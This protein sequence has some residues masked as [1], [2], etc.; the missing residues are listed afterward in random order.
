MKAVK[1]HAATKGWRVTSKAT[2]NSRGYL[3]MR[4]QRTRREAPDFEFGDRSM[5]ERIQRYM[6]LNPPPVP[7]IE[8]STKSN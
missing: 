5:E 2:R 8:V 4:I 3:G 6:A 7:P 1:M